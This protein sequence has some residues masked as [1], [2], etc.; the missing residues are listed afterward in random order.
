MKKSFFH[1][2]SKSVAKGIFD[3]LGP[4]G[5]AL[6]NKFGFRMVVITGTL[7]STTGIALSYLVVDPYTL[8]FTYGFLAG[9]IFGFFFFAHTILHICSKESDSA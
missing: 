6:A 5:S 4:V 3:L 9:K 8:Y 2:D 1:L 7:I